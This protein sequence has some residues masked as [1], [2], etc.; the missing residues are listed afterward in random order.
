MKIYNITNEIPF[1]HVSVNWGIQGLAKYFPC[2]IITLT[3]N[4]LLQ[5]KIDADSSN[6]LLITPIGHPQHAGKSLLDIKT[7]FPNSKIITLGCDTQY[8]QTNNLGFQWGNP[9]EIDLILDLMPPYVELFQNQGYK[10][11]LWIWSTSDRLLNNLKHLSPTI[12]YTRKINTFIG[13]YHPA[14]ILSGYRYE[15][16][17]YITKQGLSFTRGN[18][19]GHEDNHL[20][21]LWDCYLDSWLTLGTTSHNNN[22][23]N[24][25]G[26]MK[27]FRDWVGPVL[28]CPLIY[29]KHPNIEKIFGKI[30][31]PLYN[32]DN[33]DDLIS[34]ANILIENRDV[35]EDL[36][37]L[38]KQWVDNNTID[39]QLFNL[40]QKHEL[41]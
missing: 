16:I 18:G 33:F 39:K 11:D 31:I 40:L 21:D 5:G 24:H 27:G 3:Q 28:N 4:Q 17:Q 35:Y 15:L 32:F 34:L 6:C 8:Y 10:A 2:E 20:E 7:W 36:L 1:E 9:H 29:N 30:L 37:K 23:W 26:L 14:T 19:C 38:Q 22:H 13:V 12:D 25:L 41:F